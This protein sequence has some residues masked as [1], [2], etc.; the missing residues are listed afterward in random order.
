M[1]ESVR[2]AVRE[3][4]LKLRQRGAR[5][6]GR[7]YFCAMLLAALLVPLAVI[8]ALESWLPIELAML[9]GGCGLMATPYFLRLGVIERGEFKALGL[10]LQRRDKGFIPLE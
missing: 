10:L 2:M 5:F 1:D 7:L 3:G 9:I 4:V 8:A 6:W